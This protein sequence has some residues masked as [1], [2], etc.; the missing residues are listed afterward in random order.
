[1]DLRLEQTRWSSELEQAE[2]KYR[3]AL[4]EQDR[5][6]MAVLAAQVNQAEAQLQLVEARLARS[7]VAAPFDGV[8][9]SGDLS[10]LLGTPVEQGKVLFEVAPLDRYRVILEVDERDIGYLAL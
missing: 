3:V 2:R 1:R 10:Q 5:A 6:A 8:V 7:S 4:A 9:V